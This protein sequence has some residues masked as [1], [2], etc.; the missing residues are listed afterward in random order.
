MRASQASWRVMMVMFAG[1]VAGCTGMHGKVGA[2]A[3]D[4]SSPLTSEK[5]MGFV[6]TKD[7]AACREFYEDKL[8]L[9]LIVDDQMAL[10]FESG[11]EVIR[12]QKLKEHHPVQYTVLGWEVADIRATAAKLGAAGVKV[13]RF[14]WMKQQD[15]SGI[16]KFPNG[17]MVAW[18][19]DPDGNVLSISQLNR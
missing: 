8:G 15:E 11:R 9:R 1:L 18:M 17:D 19:Y 2:A 10:V 16:A 4:R 6:A 5:L 14:E 12:I 13:E 7:A 3:G